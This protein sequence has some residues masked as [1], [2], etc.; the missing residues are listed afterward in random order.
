MEHLE[1]KICKIFSDINCFNV[2]LISQGNGNKTRNKQMWPNQTYKLLHKKGNHKT[3]KQ[4]QPTEW[5]RAFAID[6]TENDLISKLY[7]ACIL[8]H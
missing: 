1:E 3:N 5:K 4:R 6:V 2:F 8:S 7:K